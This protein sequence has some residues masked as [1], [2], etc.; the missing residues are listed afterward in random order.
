MVRHR[1]RP[2]RR[3]L[4][5][6]AARGRAASR[7]RSTSAGATGSARS[8]PWS[9][10][11]GGARPPAAGRRLGRRRA[12]RPQRRP[13]TRCSAAAAASRCWRAGLPLHVAPPPDRRRSPRRW[14]GRA[15]CGAA[16][17]RGGDEGRAPALRLGLVG[18]GRLAEL[19]YVPAIAGLA[20]RRAR[21]GRRPGAERRE[22]IARLVAGGAPAPRAHAPPPSCWPAPASTAVVV[23]EPAGR[24]PRASAELASRA[25]IAVPGREAARRPTSRA[26]SGSPP[27]DPP[28]WVG[29]NRRFQHGA[30]AAGAIPARRPARARARASLP[31]R[32]WRRSRVRDDA[33]LDLG[34]HL[35]DLAL[36][37]SRLGARRACARPRLAPSAPSIE[38]ER[39]ARAGAD[40]LRHRSART[41]SGSSPARRGGVRR[42]ERR[43]RA[44]RGARRPRCR[45]RAHPL[46][47]SLRASSARSPPRS[48]AATRG[49]W[50]RAAEG[51]R[52]MA[53]DRRA[54][55]A[56]GGVIC[57]LQFDAAERRG[58][59]AAARPRAGCPTSRRCAGAGAGSSS[60]RPAV[61]FAAGAFYTLYSGVELGD[62]GIFYPFQW[63]AAEQRAR[64]ATA[65]EAPPAVWERLAGAGLRTLA[66]D[67]YESRPPRTRHGVFVCGWGFADR[68]VLPR[69]SRPRGA[70]RAATRAA[71]GAA[72]RR[73]RSSA[74]RGARDLLR[75]R[76][77]L[78]AAP[79]RI[80]ALAEAAARAR[81]L[82]PR[83]AHVQR[84]A[85]R[86]A[87]VLGPLPARRR[88]RSTRRARA[89]LETRARRRLRRRRRGDRAG[90]RGAAA[91]APT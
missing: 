46:V 60:R 86:R 62:H 81:A 34:P 28:P 1:P 18:C 76:E 40:P 58:A 23:A 49:C 2:P 16:G 14:R 83:L 72:R 37:L 55:R 80:A 3:S 36:L 63:S 77:K 19:G 61:D 50:R 35:V 91:P 42:P 56:Q 59:R 85:P 39:R 48:P 5:A 82:R 10:R 53:A 17:P 45:G 20:E 73:P 26:P 57:V 84:R 15:R 33:L 38:L 32:S 74:A 31:A 9:R 79:G 43:G 6:P 66:I 54:R 29:F 27:L 44:A 4:G 12:G 90:A 78:V 7:A 88:P 65:F 64:Y 13:S 11:C 69:W 8:P 89:T 75:L 22:R 71:S 24:A 47:G 70:A 68:V 52:V 25:G 87:P 30:R 41:A 51:A 21:R 67:P